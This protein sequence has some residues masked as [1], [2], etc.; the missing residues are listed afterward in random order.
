MP[1]IERSSPTRD[2]GIAAPSG[3]AFAVR[4]VCAVLI[5]VAVSAALD[6][7]EP[8]TNLGRWL[9]FLFSTALMILFWEAH[10]GQHAGWVRSVSLRV[11]VNLLFSLF[12]AGIVFFVLRSLEV[13]HGMYGPR[14]RVSE[15]VLYAGSAK[16]SISEQFQ[17]GVPLAK[18]GE[19]IDIPAK[20][21]VTFARVS[22]DGRILVY[23]KNPGAVII[24]TPS[25]QGDVGYQKLIWTCWGEPAKYMPASCRQ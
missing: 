17:T 13:E 19:G 16:T 22:P 23:G 18:A 3:I 7:A 20:G 9:I 12:F 14:V 5:G 25:A 10:I 11:L 4:A 6:T 21:M 15:L 8:V 1:A 2:E 24:M